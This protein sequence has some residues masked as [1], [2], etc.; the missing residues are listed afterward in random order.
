[1]TLGKFLQMKH[2]VR[3]DR[4]L[5]AREL[6]HKRPSPRRDQ[7][8]FGGQLL[9]VGEPDLLRADKGSARLE[10]RHLVIVERLAIETF[11]PAYLG[12][13]IVAQPCPVKAAVRDVPAELPGIMDVFGKMRAINE[14]F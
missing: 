4:M 14:Q 9:P 2:L 6:R 12:E 11:K 8:A 13:D 10:Q 1:D 3:G 5:A 7:Y